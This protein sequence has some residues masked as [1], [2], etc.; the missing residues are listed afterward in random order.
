MEVRLTQKGNHPH[1][2]VSYCEQTDGCGFNQMGV[3]SIT[4]CNIY[5]NIFLNL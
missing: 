3:A 4:V 2:L 1:P 5:I